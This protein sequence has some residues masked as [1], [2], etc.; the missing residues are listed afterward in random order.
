MRAAEAGDNC[1][2]VGSLLEDGASSCNGPITGPLGALE[3]AS[4]VR[5]WS[6]VFSV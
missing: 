2:S 4:S 1:N 6:L 3:R 5:L